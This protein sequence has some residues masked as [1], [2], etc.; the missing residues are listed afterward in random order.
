MFDHTAR[1]QPVQKRWQHPGSLGFRV[2]D[3]RQAPDYARQF[4]ERDIPNKV[5][6][7]MKRLALNS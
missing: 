4:V 6:A 5:H 7:P 3:K 1:L 2:K